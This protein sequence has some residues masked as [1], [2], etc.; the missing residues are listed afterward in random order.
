MVNN[1]AHFYSIKVYDMQRN[2]VECVIWDSLKWHVRL[3][4]DWYFKYRA[5]LFQVKYPKNKVDVS[6]G[7]IPLLTKEEEENIRLKNTIRAKKAKITELKNKLQLARD[8][9]NL[10]FPIEEDVL[11]IKCVAKIKEKENELQFLINKSM[12][13]E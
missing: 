11:Y 6:W 1:V 4:Y 2:M 7:N 13:Y 9:W 3:K 12:G 8:N 10:L 5:A